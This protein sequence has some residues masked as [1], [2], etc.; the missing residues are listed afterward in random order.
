MRLNLRLLPANLLPICL[1]LAGT[2]F[3][4]ACA[5]QAGEISAQAKSEPTQAWQTYRSDT[6]GFQLAYPAD[7][8]Y[9]QVPPAQQGGNEEVWFTHQ[10]FTQAGSGSRPDVVLVISPSDPAPA[11]EAQYPEGYTTQKIRLDGLTARKISGTNKES[12]QQEQA[13]IVHVKGAF[14]LV[15]PSGSVASL[16]AFDDM[17]ASLRPL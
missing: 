15:M 10:D 1:L 4:S 2:L 8:I 13:V 12:R 16:S 11:W 17:I 7:W 14:I 5:S 6:Y 3:A 9:V